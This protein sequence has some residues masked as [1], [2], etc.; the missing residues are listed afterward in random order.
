MYRCR[1]CRGLS[2]SVTVLLVTAGERRERRKR[3]THREKEREITERERN[4]KRT[5]RG[6]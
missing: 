6:K 1:A 2:T 3:N 5:V 4:G